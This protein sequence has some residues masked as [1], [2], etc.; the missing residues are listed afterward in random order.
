M[1]DIILVNLKRRFDNRTL[2]IIKNSVCCLGIKGFS[3]I[4]GLLTLPVYLKYLTNQSVLGVW[5]TLISMLSWIFTFDLG[6]GNGL[7]NELTKALATGEKDKVKKLISSAYISSCAICIIAVGLTLI[8]IN[9]IDFIKLFKL[10][11]QVISESILKMSLKILLVGVLIQF[12]LKLINSIL[13]AIQK[14]ALPSFLNLISNLALLIL[15][16]IMPV[17]SIE[18]NFLVLSYVYILTINVPLLFASIF[19][20]SKDLKNYSPSL[21]SFDFGL[22]KGIIKLGVVFL[23]L[24]IMAMIINSTNNFLISVFVGAKEVVNYQIY[25]K[26]FSLV[27]TFFMIGLTPVW[28]SVTD[29]MAKKDYDWII[30]LRARLF[31]L[32]GL[33]FIGEIVV[34]LCSKYVISFWM[35]SRFVLDYKCGIVVAVFDFINIG[36][37]INATIGNGLGKLKNQMIWLTIGAVINIPLSYLFSLFYNSWESIIIANIISIIPY[38]LTEIIS[39]TKYLTKLKESSSN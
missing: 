2:K 22:S 5:L 18:N 25:Y 14:S 23:W 20:F 24:Q 7:R 36:A 35:G 4:I 39:T 28:S 13:L 29:A 1:I 9:V 16:Y 19:V 6:I 33:A 10:D 31:K 15:M 32:M 30:R 8:L 11:D 12:V 38:T 37:S 26:L 21:N 34:L 3:I 17:K 27:S